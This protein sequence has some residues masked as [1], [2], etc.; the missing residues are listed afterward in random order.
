MQEVGQL[1]AI[2]SLIKYALSKVFRGYYH[3]F[4]SGSP[5]QLKFKSYFERF[6]NCTTTTPPSSFRTLFWGEGGGRMSS[7]LI[8]HIWYSRGVS[9]ICVRGVF[10]SN[11]IY[12][13]KMLSHAHQLPLKFEKNVRPSNHRLREC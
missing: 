6:I 11:R 13:C 2:R 5:S 1:M 4:L 10:Y 8:H 9:R 7:S 12:A 3:G